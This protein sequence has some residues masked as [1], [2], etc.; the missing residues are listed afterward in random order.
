MAMKLAISRNKR[1]KNT[2]FLVDQWRGTWFSS[3][4]VSSFLK[5]RHYSITHISNEFL[6]AETLVERTWVAPHTSVCLPWLLPRIWKT[7]TT[8]SP[9]HLKESALF[10]ALAS[11]A[12]LV[13]LR[14]RRKTKRERRRTVACYYYREREN[15]ARAAAT[16]SCTPL[17]H[18]LSRG[19]GRD[20]I[21]TQGVT[22]RCRLSWLTNSGLAYE[23]KCWG[24]GLLIT[25]MGTA[26]NMEHKL[27]LKIELHILTNGF[28]NLSQLFPHHACQRSKQ[29]PV[30]HLAFVDF[31]LKR[32]S[33]LEG[34][35]CAGLQKCMKIRHFINIKYIRY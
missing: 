5:Q 31:Y 8:N 13:R 10:V 25:A 4:L 20:D 24:W 35:S 21:F 27:T 28:T 22:K 14:T 32:V 9:L 26:V 1:K 34:K 3:K 23:P 2:I 16:N 19:E 7:T 29:L 15:L 33:V 11:D 12:I 17:Q 6:K 18:I 30:F